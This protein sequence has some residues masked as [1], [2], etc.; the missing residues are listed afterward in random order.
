MYI[1]HPTL[2]QQVDMVTEQC[3][4]SGGCFSAY[5][6][7]R[8]TNATTA[9]EPLLT[10]LASMVRSCC[11]HEHHSITIVSPCLA[12]LCPVP[13]APCS[14]CTVESPP[15]PCWPA[16]HSNCSEFRYPSQNMFL[17]CSHDDRSSSS[18]SCRRSCLLFGTTLEVLRGQFLFLPLLFKYS[19]VVDFR[20]T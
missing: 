5:R 20:E 18:V 19:G 17:A 14:S 6:P 13:P 10:S 9:R 15:C 11:G 1:S 16:H 3:L 2:D 4:G 7:S 8:V 12:L